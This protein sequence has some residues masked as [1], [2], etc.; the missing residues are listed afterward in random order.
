MGLKPRVEQS[1]ESIDFPAI[2]VGKDSD[3][4]EIVV[5]LGK[6][7]PFLQRGQ[8]E[9]SVSASIPE[10]LYYD[11]LTVEKAL[12]ILNTKSQRE[13]GLGICP[14]TGKKVFLLEGPCSPYV[15]PAAIN[16]GKPKRTSCRG[17]KPER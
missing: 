6:T 2:P 13:E 16:E 17:M 12:E 7:S 9:G 11:E 14:K 5:R 3:G 8:G 10:K 15:Q 1:H 4:V